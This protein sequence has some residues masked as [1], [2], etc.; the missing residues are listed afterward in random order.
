[1]EKQA[2]KSVVGD[3]K[4]PKL[5]MNGKRAA[6]VNAA[7]VTVA[8]YFGI[9]AVFGAIAGFTKGD[10]TFSMPAIVSAFFGS[11]SFSLLGVSVSVGPS[12]LF[13]TGMLALVGG[14]IG[15]LTLKKLTDAT[16]VKNAWH[17]VSEIF[18]VITGILLVALVSTALWSLFGIGEK[19]GVSQGDLWLSTFLPTL[20]KAVLA[21]TIYVL[22]R[23]IA[24]G[25]LEVLR[26]FSMVAT[27]IAVV[28]LIMVIVQTMIGFYDKKSSKSI[29]DD[30]Y[31]FD[32]SSWLD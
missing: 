5:K 14:V 28:A 19:S 26:I 7:A 3:V 29:L 30:D 16:A 21:G 25:K 13:I 2:S 11:T 6:Y 4:I 24:A 8:T 1:M 10:W 20:I 17:L 12:A 18:G 27:G 9:V 31:D 15:F 32:W 23:K 22:A